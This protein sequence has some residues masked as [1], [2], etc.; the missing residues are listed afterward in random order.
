MG[1]FP[2]WTWIVGLMVG[3]SIGS[4]LNMLIYRLPRMGPQN[5]DLSLSKPKHSF[6]PNCKHPLS[7]PDLIPLFSWLFLRG[8]CRHCGVKI[9]ARYFV[10]ELVTGIL[11]AAVWYQVLVVSPL[12]E[13]TELKLAIKALTFMLCMSALVALSWIDWESY[14]IPDSINVF[15]LVL[16]LLYHGFNGTIMVAL[17]GAFWGWALLWGIGLLGRILF[18]KD[19]MGEG[20]IMLMRGVGALVGVGPLVIA[21]GIAVALG[22][23]HGIIA[24]IV[25]AIRPPKTN[26]IQD[27]APLPEPQTIPQV[28]A[29]GGILLLGIDVIAYFVPPVGKL[30]EKALP[31]VPGLDDAEWEPPSIAYIPFGPFLA[32]GTATVMIFEPQVHNLIQ[33]YLKQFSGS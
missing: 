15:I 29:I 8:E 4:F 33:G 7:L 20:D 23:V 12:W 5:P 13:T 6:C 25:L 14:T 10:V 16:A 18:G 1:L 26:S 31:N 3:A 21:V 11:W 22:A 32:A 9:P 27:D 17:V 2:E 28:F 19:A 30:I 24:K